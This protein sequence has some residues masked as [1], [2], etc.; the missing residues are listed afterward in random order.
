MAGRM[1]DES[2]GYGGWELK[3]EHWYPHEKKLGQTDT[4]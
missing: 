2:D 4:R 1:L 3:S